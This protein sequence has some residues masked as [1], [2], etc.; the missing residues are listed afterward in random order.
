LFVKNIVEDPIDYAM[1]K[2]INEVGQLMGLETIAEFVENDAIL[3][4]LKDINVDCAQGYGLGRPR[5][6]KDLF[7]A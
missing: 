1:V 2:S 5:A 4:K 7:K 3:Q 6:L